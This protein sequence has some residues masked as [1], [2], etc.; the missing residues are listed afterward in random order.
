[1]WKIGLFAALAFV[2]CAYPQTQMVPVQDYASGP[3]QTVSAS[4]AF[5]AGPSTVRTTSPD[6]STE[7]VCVGGGT[8]RGSRVP[9]DSAPAC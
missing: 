7:F 4:P 9:P 3:R 2:G 8:M 1:M 6:G 5:T